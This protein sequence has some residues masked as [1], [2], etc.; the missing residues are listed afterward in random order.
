MSGNY[1]G[2][3][4]AATFA[5][6]IFTELYNLDL[7]DTRL[8][9]DDLIELDISLNYLENFNFTKSKI[10][11]KL[12]YFFAVDCKMTRIPEFLSVFKP[13]LKYLDSSGNY[14][15]K[16]DSATFSHFT[17]LIMLILRTTKLTFIDHN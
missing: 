2:K 3:L 8:S 7:T 6:L 10:S 12:K 9:F 15:G 17:K 16:V 5:N 1:D 13:S 14:V 4:N 11:N